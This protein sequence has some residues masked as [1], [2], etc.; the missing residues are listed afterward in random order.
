[1]N[2]II[3]GV[4]NRYN[5][6]EHAVHQAAHTFL[7]YNGPAELLTGHLRP[8]QHEA[9]LSAISRFNP[10]TKNKISSVISLFTE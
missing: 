10:Y 5:G 8:M 2:S 9:V 6:I 7:D 3:C 1:M 4:K